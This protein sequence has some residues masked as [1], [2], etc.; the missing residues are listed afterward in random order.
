L[1]YTRPQ[2]QQALAAIDEVR[3]SVSPLFC[4]IPFIGQINSPRFCRPLGG[5]QCAA[6]LFH[7]NLI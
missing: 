6:V 1:R 5:N 7:K 4:Q 3:A 2:Q